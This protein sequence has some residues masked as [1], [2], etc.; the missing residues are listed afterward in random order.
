MVSG[1]GIGDDMCSVDIC[2]KVH[3][4]LEAGRN[5]I[6]TYAVSLTSTS[7]SWWS[8]SRVDSRVEGSSNGIN[9]DRSGDFQISLTVAGTKAAQFTSSWY[10]KGIDLIMQLTAKMR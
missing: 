5:R 8:S 9:L 1:V 6:F 7:Y 10:N 2:V 3:L 4:N